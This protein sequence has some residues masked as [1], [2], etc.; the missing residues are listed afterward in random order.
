ML[1]AIIGFLSSEFGN[2]GG[3]SDKT[4]ENPT[5]LHVQNFGKHLLIQRF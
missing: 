5:P 1:P 2:V 4:G 3:T